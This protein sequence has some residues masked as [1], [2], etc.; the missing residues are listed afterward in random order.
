[1]SAF[2]HPTIWGDSRATPRL[3]FAHNVQTKL[4]LNRAVIHNRYR[5][6]SGRDRVMSGN[7]LPSTPQA[8]TQKAPQG[9]ARSLTDGRIPIN[10]NEPPREAAHFVYSALRIVSHH[11]SGVM[12]RG[13][14]AIRALLAPP[15]DPFARGQ[16][17]GKKKCGCQRGWGRGC[18][19]SAIAPRRHGGEAVNSTSSGRCSTPFLLHNRP[20]PRTSRRELPPATSLCTS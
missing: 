14:P 1:M 17:Q 13:V 12:A 18:V 4:G 7:S 3:G 5:Q 10:V 6:R 9:R 15:P 8:V 16:E 19:S 11:F 2:G 20:L